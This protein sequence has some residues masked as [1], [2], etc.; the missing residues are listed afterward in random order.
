MI[1]NPIVVGGERQ[2]TVVCS[3]A[4]YSMAPYVQEV[5]ISYV[6]EDGANQ[7]EDISNTIQ[8]Y[9]NAYLTRNV[10]MGAPLTIVL[11][12]GSGVDFG[13]SIGLYSGDTIEYNAY[14]GNCPVVRAATATTE[15]STYSILVNEQMAF[16]ING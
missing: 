7:I 10:R 11:V 4:K 3:F 1:F 16:A 2:Q 9:P 14:I 8:D 13:G 6:D 5:Y 12:T 15:P